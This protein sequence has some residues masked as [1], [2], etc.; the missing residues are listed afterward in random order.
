[1]KISLIVPVFNEEDAIPIFYHAA[2][3]KLSAY[4]IEFVFIDDGS[5]DT[6]EQVITSM[7]EVDTAVKAISLI[8]NFGKESALLAGLEHATGDAVIPIDVDLQDPIEIIPS[9][10][11]KWQEGWPVVLAKRCDRNSD[12]HFKRKTAIWFY[13]L[14]NKISSPKIEENVGDFRLLSRET[15]ENIKLLQGAQSVYER[16]PQLGRG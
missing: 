3:E 10:I 12:S 14:H 6:T 13:R 7:A 8:R 1:M 2:K 11:S 9:L 5:T 15:V 4:N 16:A